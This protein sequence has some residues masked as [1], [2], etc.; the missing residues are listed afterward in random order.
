M[1]DKDPMRK[2]QREWHELWIVDDCACDDAM[3]KRFGTI[4]EIA[5]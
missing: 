4:S 2:K 3:R 1:F 5:I